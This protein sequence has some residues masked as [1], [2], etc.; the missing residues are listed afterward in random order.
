MVTRNPATADFVVAESYYPQHILV[1]GDDIQGAFSLAQ[2][3]KAN[4]AFAFN[5]GDFSSV[6]GTGG[7]YSVAGTGAGKI[8]GFSAP[9]IGKEVRAMLAWQGQ[10]DDEVLF[11]YQG[12]NVAS[13]AP[14]MNKGPAAQELAIQFRGELP[15]TN[16]DTN[17]GHD[18]TD[19]V[20]WRWYLAG[21]LFD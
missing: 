6:A 5:A 16:P 20:P 8:A 4:L 18:S 10:D 19:V 11:I 21:T 1:T 3:N 9:L 15:A 7:N 17:L 12:L 13:V 2:V 14:A